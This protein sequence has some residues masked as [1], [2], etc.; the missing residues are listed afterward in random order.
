M[1]AIANLTASARTM[2]RAEKSS[3]T[4]V[5]VRIEK[6]ARAETADLGIARTMVREERRDRTAPRDRDV[7]MAAI[8]SSETVRML[9]R[10]D[11]NLI[12][13]AAA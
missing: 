5:M 10:K 6:K 2:V 13:T 11:A 12:I 1:A 9:V 8:A 7:R 3:R 4:D